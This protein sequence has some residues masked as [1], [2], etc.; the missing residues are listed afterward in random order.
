MEKENSAQI[1]TAHDAVMEPVPQHA[2]ELAESGETYLET[3]LVM[4][5]RSDNF[6]VRAVDVANELGF[7]KP[8]VSRALSQLKEKGLVKIGTA[9]SLELTPAGRQKAESIFKRHQLLTVF[10]SFTAK[11]PN[12]VAEKDACRIEH[13]ISDQTMEGIQKY[14]EENGV[15]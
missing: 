13:I 11:V 10:L 9:G 6:I 3:I 5:E 4:K 14:L 15:I 8:S 7:S 1:P 2:G 12:D